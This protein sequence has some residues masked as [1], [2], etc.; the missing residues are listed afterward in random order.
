MSDDAI[1]AMQAE[2]EGIAPPSDDGGDDE[3]EAM[4]GS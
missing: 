1:A 4:T 2:A 3:P